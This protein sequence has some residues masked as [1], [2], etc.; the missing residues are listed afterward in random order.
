MCFGQNLCRG[1]SRA[2]ISK[3][4]TGSDPAKPTGPRDDVEFEGRFVPQRQLLDSRN[5]CCG[6]FLEFGL[7]D[8]KSENASIDTD[9][10]EMLCVLAGCRFSE[11]RRQV[12]VSSE[13]I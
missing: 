1:R 11:D 8:P 13:S 12:V 6:K 9:T 2:A 10:K 3:L 7:I 5:H 4:E